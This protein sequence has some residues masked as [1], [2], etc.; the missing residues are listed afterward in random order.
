[1]TI[2]HEFDYVRPASLAEAVRAL[3]KLGPRAQV[4]AGGTDLVGLLQDDLVQPSAVLDLKGIG[5]LDELSFKKNVLFIG[6]L[7][8]FSDLLASKMIRQKFPVM[9]EMARWVASVGIRN[10]ATIVGNICSAVPC[11][12]SGPVLLAYGAQ[13]VVRGARGQRVVPVARWFTG[14]RKTALKRGEIVTG[15]RVPHPVKKHAGCFVKL[16]RVRGED[17]AQ[18]SVTVLLITGHS[19]RIAFGSVAPTPVRGAEIEALLAG[20]KLTDDLVRQAAERVP[21]EI[22]PITDVRASKEY[23]AQMVAVMLERALIA[24][25]ARFDG[26]GPEYGAE[27]M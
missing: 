3:R 1:M 23:R 25:S 21:R 27:L 7:V 2:A 11:C 22:A 14:P 15:L 8:T 12:D 24:A 19:Y 18:A 6:P 13:V 20:R 26:K 5:G 9:A 16:M 4:L 10:R 17:L